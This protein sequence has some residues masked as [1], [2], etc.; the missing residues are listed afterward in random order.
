[1]QKIF[2]TVTF[3]LTLLTATTF[4][5]ENENKNESYEYT[6]ETY[7]FKI[8]CPAKPVVVVNPFEDPK[9]KGELLVFANDGMKIIYGYQIKLD[10]FNDIAVPDF[11]RGKKQLID[12]YIKNLNRDNAYVSVKLE[13]VTPNNKGVVLVTAKEIE[14]TNEK[15]EVVETLT[16]EEQSAF[17]FFRSRSGRCISIQL[18]S[19]DLDESDY[20][21]Y[22]KSVATYQ[23][24]TDLSMP[25]DTKGK[26]SKK[27]K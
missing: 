3:I 13:T 4:A 5:A 19:A 2:L 12:D 27:K 6:S 9:Q 22:R 26:K 23:D 16:A 21:D 7:G 8:T 1:M 24:A 18:I 14:I 20:N 25:Q 11:N 17:T 10:A 15:G